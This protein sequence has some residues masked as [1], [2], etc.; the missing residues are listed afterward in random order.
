MS[1][2]YVIS[3]A[4]GMIG[5]AVIAALLARGDRVIALVRPHSSRAAG[6]PAHERLTLLSCD[7]SDYRDHVP[8]ERA[9]VFLH[10]AWAATTGQGREDTALQLQNVQYTLDAV[11][12]AHRFGCEAFVGAGSQAEYGPASAPLAA[13]SPTDPQSGYGVGKYAAGKLSRIL[14]HQLGMRHCWARILSIYGE[15]DGAGT[16]IMYLIRALLAGETPALTPCEQIWDYLY[17]EDAARALI[18]IADRGH[19]GAVYPVGS[20]KGRPL[21]EYV[22]ALRDI[23]A[24]QAELAIGARPYYPHQPMLLVADITELTAHTGFLPRVPFEEGI[25]R[26]LRSITES[27]AN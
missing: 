20:G 4:T 9:D 14:C 27:E 16:L 21:Y 17:V 10:L 23:V 7:L 6:L 18:A 5:R 11:Q 22:T 12:L 15:G 24:P 25:G 3:G 8:T 13:T 26:V 2:T 19:D 1:K